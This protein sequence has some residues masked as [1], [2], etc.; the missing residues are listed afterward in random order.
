MTCYGTADRPRATVWVAAGSGARAPML[1]GFVRGWK[2]GGHALRGAGALGG[3]V[4]RPPAGEER[5]SGPAVVRTGLQA[6]FSLVSPGE[7]LRQS[8]GPLTSEREPGSRCYF[9]AL[10]SR[11]PRRESCKVDVLGGVELD[12]VFRGGVS[13]PEG[14]PDLGG[15][16]EGFRRR[17]RESEHGT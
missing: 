3:G 9:K 2:A 6:G 14:L 7:T 12:G 4:V 15:T 11:S 10:S 13:R 16:A 17:D 8:P 1:R 5:G